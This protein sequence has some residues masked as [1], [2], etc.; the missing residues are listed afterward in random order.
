MRFTWRRTTVIIALVAFGIAAV[1]VPATMNLREPIALRESPFSR[2]EELVLIERIRAAP[3]AEERSRLISELEKLPVKFHPFYSR[4]IA[5][6]D[7]DPFHCWTDNG[8]NPSLSDCPRDIQILD[9]TDYGKS[10]I[11]NGGFHQFF[12]NS[13]GVFAPEMIEWFDTQDSPRPRQSC[14]RQLPCSV[15]ISR[16]RKPIEENS[17]PRSTGPRERNGIHST[18]WMIDSMQAS[19]M[20]RR[21]STRPQIAGCATCAES[22]TFAI[23]WKVKLDAEPERECRSA[24]TLA[25]SSLSPSRPGYPAML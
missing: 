8:Y 5:I 18:N 25:M 1:L 21:Y 3:S 14:D 15:I 20:T 10:D 11:D 9:A 23:R 4:W 17:W 12:S 13:T 2:D 7:A 16:V 6:N 22:R 19:R 24:L